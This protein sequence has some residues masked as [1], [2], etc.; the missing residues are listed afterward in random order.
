MP[1]QL[2]SSSTD[3]ATR[4]ICPLSLHD[5]L[6]IFP[7]CPK[8]LSLLA[9]PVQCGDFAPRT[10]NPSPKGLGSC[11]P[12]P[13]RSEEHTSELQSRG[14]LVCRLLLEQKKHKR[15]APR[16]RRL[17]AA[18]VSSFLSMSSTHFMPP[19][20]L[21]TCALF[22]QCYLDHPDLH[23]FPTRRSSDLPEV[24]EGALA[25][26][27]ARPVRRLRAPH[28]EPQS[29]GVGVLL[30]EA[31]HDAH[32][33]GQLGSGGLAVPPG[34]QQGRARCPAGRHRHV[35]GGAEGPHRGGPG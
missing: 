13:D 3:P 15:T 14:H 12:K 24:P 8:V 6:P 7:K 1:S 18:P 34:L 29:E 35:R 20:P 11:F 5:A 28:L 9:A 17:P 2:I 16:V 23:S 27:S 26:G 31:G 19:P 25:V 30:P 21:S 32:Q 22:L 10:S 33:F 4:K